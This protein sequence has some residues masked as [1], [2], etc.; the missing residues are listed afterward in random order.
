MSPGKLLH[1]RNFMRT[2]TLKKIEGTLPVIQFPRT[3]VWVAFTLVCF[4][5]C[6]NSLPAETVWV[7]RS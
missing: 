2:K 6:L 4:E 5:P 7:D 1:K 3:A